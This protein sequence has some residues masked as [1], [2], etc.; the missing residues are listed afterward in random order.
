MPP[1]EPLSLTI[2]VVDFVDREAG[3]LRR[4]MEITFA[5]HEKALELAMVRLNER[6][7]EM[8]QFR[9]QLVNERNTYLSRERFDTEHGTLLNRTSAIELQ[10]SKWSGSLLAL[11]AAISAIVVGVNIMMKL[12]VK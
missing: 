9:A 10:Q 4:E 5:A 2:P 8:N 11:G 12:W 1:P 7:E 3:H 6:L